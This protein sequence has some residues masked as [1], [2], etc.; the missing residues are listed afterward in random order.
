VPAATQSVITGDIANKIRAKIIAEGANSP[1]VPDADEVLEKK[2]VFIIPDILC[3]AGGVF[4]SYLEY[5]QET[6]REQITLE[7]VNSRLNNRIVSKF[8]E[9]YNYSKRNNLTMRQA[10]MNMAVSRVV[11]ATRAM[12]VLP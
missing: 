1:T 3:N 11:E 7:E 4:V 12:G 6:Q 9:V 5:T 10:A 8:N 2:K